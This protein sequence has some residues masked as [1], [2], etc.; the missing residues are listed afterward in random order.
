MPFNTSTPR[1]SS[2]GE[3][4]RRIDL[5][6]HLAARR[7]DAHD[8]VGLPDVGVDLPVNTF[9][10]V[11]LIDCML[12]WVTDTLPCSANVERLRKYNWFVPSDITSRVPSSH[13]P[14]PSVS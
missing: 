14:Q 6:G 11:E 1:F 10:L 13:R 9:E 3:Q 8:L 12:F 4:S 7:I 2:G 5:C